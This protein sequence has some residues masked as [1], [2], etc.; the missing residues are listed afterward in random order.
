MKTVQWIAGFAFSAFTALAAQ[1][2]DNNWSVGVVVGNPYP[3]PVTYYAAPPVYYGPPPVTIY[4]HPHS[5]RYYGPA[6]YGQPVYAAPVMAYPPAMPGVIQ[7][8]YGSG[9]YRNYAPGPRGYGNGWGHGH[10]GHHQR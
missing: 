9:S 8:S 10:G 2:H 4:P 7:F 1:A 6:A 3:P 5:T